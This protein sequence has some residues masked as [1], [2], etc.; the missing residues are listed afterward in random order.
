MVYDKNGN[1]LVTQS[2][3]ET[4]DIPFDFA[5]STMK[6]PGQGL[7]KAGE[8]FVISDAGSA[9]YD[10][11]GSTANIRVFDSSFASAGRMTHNLG[12]GSG[13]SYNQTYDV[14]LMGNGE[15][16]VSPRL[17][18]LLNA[19]ANVSS[20]VGG[21]VPQYLFGGSN[22][23]S[24]FLTKNGQELLPGADGATWCVAGNDRLAIFSLRRADKARV[25]YLAMLGVGTVDFSSDENGYGTFHS[26]KASSEL[27]GTLKVLKKFEP[28]GDTINSAQGMAYDGGNLIVSSSTSNCLIYKIAFYDDGYLISDSWK[29][30]FYNADG[31]E[32]S[33]E[34]EGVV[35]I[36]EGHFYC[37]TT[38]GVLYFYA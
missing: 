34:P 12:H 28:I 26:G 9:S 20:A 19:S 29:C 22:V 18:I 25:F 21:S 11:A 35:K 24:I 32:L 1:P 33:C 3:P 15:A 7:C 5:S 23:M 31:T 17:D 13:I 2:T 4:M 30:S 37:A 16:D 10:S 36:G 38:Q 27:N 8:N 6:S 14:F